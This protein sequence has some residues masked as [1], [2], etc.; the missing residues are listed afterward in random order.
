MQKIGILAV[1]HAESIE[2]LLET[3]KGLGWEPGKTLEL[4]FPPPSSDDALLAANMQQILSENVELVVAQTRPGVMAATKATRSV[5]IVM[6]AFNG[7]PVA[8]G[9]VESVG[10][11][12]R[13]VTGTYYLGQAG[14]AERLLL[15]REL[16]PNVQHIG[17]L[18]N[19]HSQFSIDL[20]NK[21]TEA[22]IGF[23]LT[24]ILM[25]A[26]SVEEV[27]AAFASVAGKIQ[28]VVTV[29]GADMYSYRDSI[30]R[31]ADKF[32]LPT[33]MGSIGYPEL[34]GLA[35][36][37]P[38]IPVLWKKMASAHVDKILR[39]QSPA[40]LPLVKLND[41]ELTINIRTAE[42]FGISVPQTLRERASKLIV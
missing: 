9:L 7:D 6:G 39:G 29:T 40:K 17:V 41:F 36:L 14:I 30:V 1:S 12:G 4:I 31:A 13:N 20:A 42:R 35:K 38:D 24:S 15:V 3:L 18:M 10:R 5:P 16:L 23:S 11:P 37:G 22:A 32:R 27:E 33:V 19:P 26:S 21:V 8:E 28:A 2:V 25:G 34:G